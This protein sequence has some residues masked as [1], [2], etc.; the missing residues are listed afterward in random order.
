MIYLIK[1]LTTSN[2]SNNISN[3]QIS[4]SNCDNYN[5][6]ISVSYKNVK[7]KIKSTD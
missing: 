1:I 2:L 6:S 4:I 3:W 5:G 7:S